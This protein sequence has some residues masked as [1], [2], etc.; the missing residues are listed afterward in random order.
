MTWEL[1]ADG[2]KALAEFGLT[3]LCQSS[4]LLALGMLAG[5]MLRRS[6]PA[7]QSAAYRTTLAAVLVCPV[8]STLLASLGLDGVTLRLPV[9]EAARAEV[10]PAR[11]TP[12]LVASTA[13]IPVVRPPVNPEQPIAPPSPAP[14]PRLEAARA[15][16]W[17]WP[18]PLLPHSPMPRA[19][20]RD[21]LAVSV[22]VGLGV[23]AAGALLMGLRLVVGLRAMVR[24]RGSA[25]PAG[26]AEEALC[27]D[28]ARRMKLAP[29][30]VLLA[31]FLHSPCVDGLRRPAILLPDDSGADLRDTFVHE[32]AH[33]ARRDIWWNLLR[34]SASAL[35]WF[36]PLLWV[37]S[38]RMEVT[39]EEVCD[40]YVVQFGA[41]RVSYA[42]LLVELARRTLPPVPSMAVGMIS[43]RSLLARRVVR[44]LD[45]SR[46]P[47]TRAGRRAVLLMLIAGLAGT[48]LAGL[49]GVGSPRRQAR[50]ET[51][52]GDDA[53]KAGPIR[54][55]VVGP[56]G[57]PVV[58]AWVVAWSSTYQPDGVGSEFFAKRRHET[59]IRVTGSDGR[60]EVAGDPSRST[61]FAR[62]PGFGPG[63]RK[64]DGTI[65]LTE[66]DRAIHGRLVDLE[67]RPVEGASIRL[68]Q[69]YT[70]PD[71]KD[72]GDAESRPGPYQFPYDKSF[73]FDGEA[74]LPG[75][76]V[77]DAD[78]RFRIEGLGIDAVASLRITGPTIARKEVKVMTRAM[79]RVTRDDTQ[80]PG[81][82][83]L[84]EPGLYGADCTIVAQAS[85]PIEGSVRD[86]ETGEPIPGAIVTAYQ[87]GGQNLTIEGQI[88]ATTDA[89]GH[90]R[91]LG[92]PVG[93]GHRL[94]V[95][96]PLDR[97]YFITRGLAVPSLVGL[98]PV[99]FDIRL[100]R[101]SWIAGR[102][103][104]AKTD[105]PVKAS[106]DYFPFLANHHA[107]DYANFI[108]NGG[109]SIEVKTRYRTDDEG[110]FRVVGLPGRGVVVARAD[111]GAYLVGF[112]SEAIA[113]KDNEGH[114]PTFDRISPTIYQAIREVDVPVGQQTTLRD[115]PVDPG[116]SVVLKFVDEAGKPVEQVVAHGLVPVGADSG[117]HN[118]YDHATSAKVGGLEPGKPRTV[119]LQQGDRK[120]GARRAVAGRRP[121][122]RARR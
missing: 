37:L 120:L 35:L 25:I 18:R 60:Y 31:P 66:G 5:R 17:P 40:D 101:G 12:P 116:D 42:G 80:E 76:V 39:A 87:V 118:V 27:L 114:L 53:K 106:V 103:F 56:D 91:L 117:D 57:G 81:S 82:M 73:G 3:W 26:P 70:L 15:R 121:E 115:L 20:S 65:T 74:T 58:G 59:T 23:W 119:V 108:D 28:L 32:L 122:G 100:R 99:S 13:P 30:K 7:V 41:N 43:F 63:Y 109:F 92:L 110:R 96:P 78:G 67:G 21:W 50:A 52:A 107:K 14:T 83:G 72:R 8:A 2:P 95:Y 16:P 19:S 45:S 38:R 54:G 104:D 48:S 49:L 11:S 71:P 24:L 47:S 61:I 55:R 90:Y 69:L 112:G 102:V 89:E 97:P 79:A 105:R 64:E 44:I 6:G 34:Q 9:A 88:T 77:T 22:A 98:D 36:Q 86:L 46:A 113:G 1:L 51:K 94:S 4:A 10:A 111:N 33:L 62:A 75:G 93:N 29:P 84:E 68:L 85:R